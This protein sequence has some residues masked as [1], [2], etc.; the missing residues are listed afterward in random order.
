VHR[1]VSLGFASVVDQIGGYRN[2]TCGIR[3]TT[4]AARNET[5]LELEPEPEQHYK[6]R[7]QQL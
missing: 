3:I 4:A 7:H 2:T 1:Q 6:Q 5:E